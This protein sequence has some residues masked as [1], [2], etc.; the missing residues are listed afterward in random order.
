MIYPHNNYSLCC[1]FHNELTRNIHPIIDSSNFV[2]H[3]NSAT[4]AT[5]WGSD[6]QFNGKLR[7]YLI[8][9]N[10]VTAAQFCTRAQVDGWYL[11]ISSPIIIQSTAFLAISHKIS[12]RDLS[13]LQ[14]SL[15]F[16][17]PPIQ[18]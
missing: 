10:V 12:S 9:K 8:K 18:K 16:S 2:S 14:L 5:Q 17:I 15:V 13:L 11:Q 4:G 6:R 1:S 7:F 3:L